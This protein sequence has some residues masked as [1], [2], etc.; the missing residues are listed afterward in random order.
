[1]SYWD[2]LNTLINN[3][4]NGDESDVSGLGLQ[5]YLKHILTYLRDILFILNL[6]YLTIQDLI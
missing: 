5:F 4:I 2:N 1:M 3:T 6:F